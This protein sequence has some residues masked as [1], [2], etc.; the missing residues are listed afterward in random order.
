MPVLKV[1][2]D[3]SDTEL[4]DTSRQFLMNLCTIPGRRCKN[5][6]QQRSEV[7]LS[8]LDKETFGTSR[9]FLMIQRT[10]LDHLCKQK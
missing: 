7:A 5:L 6:R 8:S 10:K 2:L 9:Q 1:V 3:T 4:S